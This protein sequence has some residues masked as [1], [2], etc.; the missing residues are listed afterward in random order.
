MQAKRKI[1]AAVSAAGAG[2]AGGAYYVHKHKTVGTHRGNSPEEHF[3]NSV[4]THQA[5][6]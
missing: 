2:V 4:D 1:I 3:H 5:G 6:A